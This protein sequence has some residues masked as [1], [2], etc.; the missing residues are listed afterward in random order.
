MTHRKE[1]MDKITTM[2]EFWEEAERLDPDGFAK[3]R[4]ERAE[5]ETLCKDAERYRRI[6]TLGWIDDAIMTAYEIL[7]D[8]PCTLD[9]AV[10]A[11]IVKYGVLGD[12]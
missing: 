4:A 2:A 5:M 1:T 6:R 12:A 10:D 3:A 8:N 7:D 9:S 11:V